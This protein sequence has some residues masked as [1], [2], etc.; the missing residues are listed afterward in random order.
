[1]AASHQE[2]VGTDKTQG[3]SKH[4][5]MLAVDK[6]QV[7]ESSFVQYNDWPDI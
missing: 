1:M 6:S 2:R 3:A 7:R 5:I 4:N